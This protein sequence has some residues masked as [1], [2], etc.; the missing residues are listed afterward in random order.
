MAKCFFD[1]RRLGPYFAPS[2]FRFIAGVDVSLQ[3]GQPAASQPARQSPAARRTWSVRLLTKS[4]P[5][6]SVPP[7]SPQDLLLYDPQTSTSLRWL[8]STPGAK[9]L[10]LDFE[11]VSKPRR[12]AWTESGSLG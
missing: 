3:V 1:G 12:P 7:S 10:A 6:M 11:E 8:L 9:S 2:L 5:C 4:C